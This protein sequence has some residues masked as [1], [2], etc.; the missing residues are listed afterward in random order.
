M[1]KIFNENDRDFSTNGNIALKPLKCVEYKKKSLNGWYIECEIP[2]K[3][4]D[5]IEKG[6]TLDEARFVHVKLN[7]MEYRSES[8]GDKRF[9]FMVSEP[10]VDVEHIQ[11]FLSSL[12]FFIKTEWVDTVSMMRVTVATDKELL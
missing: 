9:V 5:Y 12:G 11:N 8:H 6:L 1:I 2:I 3:Y 10:G 7:D 4:K